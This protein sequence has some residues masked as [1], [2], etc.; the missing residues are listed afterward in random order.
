MASKSPRYSRG[1]DVFLQARADLIKPVGSISLTV[2]DSKSQNVPEVVFVRRWAVGV[3]G[4]WKGWDSWVR[5]RANGV[6]L[7]AT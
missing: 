7:Q 3:L 6:S 5:G 4:I 2:P 1:D